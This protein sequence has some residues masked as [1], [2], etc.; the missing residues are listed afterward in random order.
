MKGC[1]DVA[2]EIKSEIEQFRPFLPL[3]QSLRNP[4]MRNRHWE[5]LSAQL[6]IVIKPKAGLTFSKCLEMGLQN[7]INE[8]IKIAEIAS[9]EF[10]IEQALDKMEQEWEPQLLEI[11][12]YKTTGKVTPLLYTHNI[13][14][15]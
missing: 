6:G 1:L 11:I 14:T 2:D 13:V 7:H 4:G 15:L 10:S 12:S 8:I 9:K 5:K 3:I